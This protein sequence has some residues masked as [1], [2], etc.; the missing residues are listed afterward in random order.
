MPGDYALIFTASY[1]IRI[2]IV[3]EVFRYGGPRRGDIVLFCRDDK[4]G[5]NKRKKMALR[6]FGLPGEEVV[7]TDKRLI[8]DGIAIDD[9]YANFDDDMAIVSDLIKRDNF[10]PSVVPPD[11]YLLL[12]DRRDVSADGRYFGVTGRGDIIGK[13]VGIYWSREPA[14]GIFSAIRLNRIGC[15]K[16]RLTRKE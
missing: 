2:P 6:V 11:A 7:I 5:E 15:V 9:G 16:N 12:G 8:I 1:G 4:D 14:A 3:G 10:G 13:V